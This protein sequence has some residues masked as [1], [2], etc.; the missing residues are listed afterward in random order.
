V[1]SN[2]LADTPGHVRDRLQSERGEAPGD[3]GPFGGSLAPWISTRLST[4]QAA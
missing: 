4:L 3:A 2:P 1:S